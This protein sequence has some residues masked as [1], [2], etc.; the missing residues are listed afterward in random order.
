MSLIDRKETALINYHWSFLDFQL[1]NQITPVKEA[2]IKFV[3]AT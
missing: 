3:T 2:I 1:L